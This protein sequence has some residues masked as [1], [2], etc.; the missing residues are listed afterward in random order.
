MKLNTAAKEIHKSDGLGE[1][2]EF[3]MAVT[4]QSF[5]VMSSALYSNKIRAVIRELSCNAADAHVVA[6]N[7][8]TPYLVHLPNNIDRYFRIRDF[9]TGLSKDQIDSIYTQYFNSTKT[10]TNDQIGC[11]G[12]GSKSPFAY[13][14]NFS[15]TSFFDGKKFVYAA[16]KN[17]RNHPAISMI[18]EEDTDEPNGLEIRMAVRKSDFY[19]FASEAE[20][21]YKWFKLK[22]SFEGSNR[23]NLPSITK[24]KKGT[25]WFTATSGSGYYK[26]SVGPG[27]LM[28]NIL[29]SVQADHLETY[30]DEELIDALNVVKPI[31][32][33]PVGALNFQ[34]SRENLSYDKRTI[35]ALKKRLTDIKDQLNLEAATLITKASTKWEAFLELENA[36][37]NKDGI[38]S[39]WISLKLKKGYSIDWNGEKLAPTELVSLGY[40]DVKYRQTHKFWFEY[41]WR[42]STNATKYRPG[43]RTKFSPEKNLIFVFVDEA[44]RTFS[45]TKFRSWMRA[46]VDNYKE[47]TFLVIMKEEN[48]FIRSDKF[49]T[50]LTNSLGAKLGENYLW[51][52]DMPSTPKK[53]RKGGG[54]GG[55]KRTA[56]KLFT[57]RGS[58]SVYTRSEL[59]GKYK[60]VDLENGEGLYVER[61]G[62]E[63]LHNGVTQNRIPGAYIPIY[64]K[65]C[66]KEDVIDEVCSFTPAQ[67]KKIGK[68]W[69]SLIDHLRVEI[70]KLWTEKMRETLFINNFVDED[71]LANQKSLNALATELDCLNEVLDKGANKDLWRVVGVTSLTSPIAV[72]NY[73]LNQFWR[74]WVNETGD[75]KF[76]VHDKSKLKEPQD[77]KTLKS[78]VDALMEKHHLF[79]YVMANEYRRTAKRLRSEKP[80]VWKAIKTCF[81]AEENL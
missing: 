63:I 51:W 4:A 44:Q 60:D 12:L 72:D 50:D 6:G 3:T 36:K 2:K 77:A 46:F 18:A 32:E 56:S 8:N 9:G 66:A 58:I 35:A 20:E 39:R 5:H 71:I 13:T 14:D 33:F 19:R 11:L 55:V 64:N 79:F 30:L 28:G 49:F 68:G 34:P 21:V 69:V 62:S 53:K 76:N 27:A 81:L 45:Q 65:L 78:A 74:N 22:P 25:G 61:R 52:H 54:N 23:P 17:D 37:N 40:S 15:I 29:Y 41:N 1:E 38:L 48:G 42:S 10:D 75:S 16:F 59:W 57:S 7:A 73:N 70:P 31:L 26:D 80:K 67:M 24:T 43:T 47:T